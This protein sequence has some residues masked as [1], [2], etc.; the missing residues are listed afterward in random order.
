[1][2]TMWPS[3]S[4]PRLNVGAS[5]AREYRAAS[6]LLSG[7]V[8][9][10]KR[11]GRLAMLAHRAAAVSNPKPAVP[12][13]SSCGDLRGHSGSRPCVS[14]ASQCAA[15]VRWP[16]SSRSSPSKLSTGKERYCHATAAASHC[17]FALAV[18]TNTLE[19]V[20]TLLSRPVTPDHVAAMMK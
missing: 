10:R 5:F 4:Y 1:M 8:L 13:V 3:T 20:T 16:Y 11:S 17:T 6:V 7:K 12:S 9:M 14:S 15:K 18:F 19:P 2:S